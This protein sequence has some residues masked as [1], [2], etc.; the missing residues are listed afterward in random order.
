MIPDF[1]SHDERDS[2]FKEHAQYFTLVKKVNLGYERTEYKTLD[3]AQKAG[4]TKQLI[5]GGGWMIYA[6]M[7]D[8]QS[9]LVDTV[10]PKGNK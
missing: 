5:G 1:K 3:A 6:V 7:A 4:Q 2:Y 8:G 10:K 9:A